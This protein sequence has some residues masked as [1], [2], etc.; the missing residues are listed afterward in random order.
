MANRLVALPCAV[1]LASG[2]CGFGAILVASGFLTTSQPTLHAAQ[3]IMLA[4]ILDG[5]D[6]NLARA[7][8]AT[9][10]FGAQLDTFMDMLSFGIAPALL[11]ASRRDDPIVC[12]VMAAFVASCALRLSRFRVLQ[13]GGRDQTFSGL[14]IT[15][16]AAWA[17]LFVI[18]EPWSGA[19]FGALAADMLS[20]GAVAVIGLFAILQLTAI[21][22]PKPTRSWGFYALTAALVLGLL[23]PGY[24]RIAC[25]ALLMIGGLAYALLPALAQ[26]WEATRGVHSASKSME[27]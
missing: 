21:A 25:A 16:A 3:L 24:V 23:G 2:L 12:A 11:L 8:N 27:Y 26:I 1:T 19:L 17:C 22:Y 9:S 18:T 10:E 15:I 13:I 5:L 6:G 4:M 7:L 14:P 20:W